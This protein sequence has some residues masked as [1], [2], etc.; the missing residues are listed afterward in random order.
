M[1][2]PYKPQHFHW[3]AGEYSILCSRILIRMV[4]LKGSKSF[5]GRHK[6][7]QATKFYGKARKG[8]MCVRLI[9]AT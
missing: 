6:F 4:Y 7:L 8:G 9:L 5:G 2:I 1:V 3:P